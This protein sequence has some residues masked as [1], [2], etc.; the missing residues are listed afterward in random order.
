M[1]PPVA[2]AFAAAL[3]VVLAGCSSPAN[4]AAGAAP[5]GAASTMPAG[6][7]T[8]KAPGPMT[9]DNRTASLIGASDGG[10]QVSPMANSDGTQQHFSVPLA[11]AFI[12]ITVST[13][14]TLPT[15]SELHMQVYPAGCVKEGSQMPACATVVDTKAGH[16]E[17]T[18]D[19]PDAG[20]WAVL[21]YLSGVGA[22]QVSY[23]LS[24]GIES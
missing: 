13:K 6:N 9:Y 20:D 3:L 15:T 4:P 5:S 17:F 16:A 7:A 19:L 1:R 2:V 24:I 18:D 21:F 12:R 10:D 8:V 11:S 22:N 23:D 14:G